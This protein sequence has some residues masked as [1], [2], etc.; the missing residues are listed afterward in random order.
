MGLLLVKVGIIIFIIHLKQQS[1]FSTSSMMNSYTNENSGVN[2]NVT[3]CKFT[4]TVTII[5]TMRMLII[6]LN[7]QIMLFKIMILITPMNIF[8]NLIIQQQMLQLI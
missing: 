4:T 6:I 1:R 2:M 3:N 8:I 7:S 5:Q